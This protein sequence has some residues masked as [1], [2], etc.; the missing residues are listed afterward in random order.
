M[1]FNK[2]KCKVLNLTQGNPKP[3]Q[4][5]NEEKGLGVLVNKRLLMSQQ[6]ALI[7]QKAK[8]ILGCVRSSVASRTRERILRLH[9]A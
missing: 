8:H 2:T 5:M 3:G 4:R 9:F 6:R 7:A 1:K